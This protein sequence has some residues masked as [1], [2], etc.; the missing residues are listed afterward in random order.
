MT[1]IDFIISQIE[2]FGKYRFIKGE[3][4]KR[5]LDTGAIAKHFKVSSR[6]VRLVMRDQ[7]KSR[8]IASYLESILGVPPGTLFP[9]VTQKPRRGKSR[10]KKPIV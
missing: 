1:T 6:A 4:V 10:F 7:I 8:R 3:L 5:G 9:Y 2:Q